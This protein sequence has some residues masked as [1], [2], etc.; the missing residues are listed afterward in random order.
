MYAQEGR[1]GRWKNP[2]S[3]AQQASTRNNLVRRCVMR[4]TSTRRGRPRPCRRCHEQRIGAR[5]ALG[6]GLPSARR[7]AHRPE[8]RQGRRARGFSTAPE[9]YWQL[10]NDW[11]R[12]WKRL[13]SHGADAATALLWRRVRSSTPGESSSAGPS[14]LTRAIIGIRQHGH[15]QGLRVRR[16]R[17]SPARLPAR[18]PADRPWPSTAPATRNG[19]C[20]KKARCWSG[21]HGVEITQAP[22]AP[23]ARPCRYAPA[24]GVRRRARAPVR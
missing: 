7:A 17:R 22:P 21:R 15:L 1:K 9:R 3:S 14:R 10:P 19:N 16:Y 5:S 18:R 11:P 8:Q 13:L 23:C 12:D 20:A 2:G 6:F 4:E 24:T